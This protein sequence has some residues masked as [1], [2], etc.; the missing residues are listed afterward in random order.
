MLKLAKDESGIAILWVA[1]SMGIIVGAAVLAIDLS[2]I[3]TTRTQLQN[4]ADAAALAAA[5]D[6]AWKGTSTLA[7][8]RQ[9]ATNTAIAIAALNRAFIDRTVG[10][11]NIS[12]S[13]VTFPS[14]SEVTVRTHRTVADGDPL[15]TY[16]IRLIPPFG[17]GLA[18]VQADATAMVAPASGTRGFFPWVLPDRYEDLDGDGVWDD[19][20]P[21]TDQNGNG[22]WDDD[23]PYT[24]ANGN[25]KW[26]VG[27]WFDDLDG[28]GEYSLRE[29]FEDLDGNGIYSADF[30]D[31]ILTG[32]GTGELYPHNDAGMLLVVAQG[33]PQST[34]T[35][36]FYYPAR[37]PPEEYYT[38]E[39]PLSGASIYQNWIMNKSPYLVQIG[40]HV[41]LEYGRM[42]GPTRSGVNDIISRCPTSF[43]NADLDPPGVDGHSHDGSI[44][45]PRIG[46]IAFFDPADVQGSS[47]KLVTI[48]KL[49]HWFVESMDQQNTVYGRLIEIVDALAIGGG[50][51]SGGFIVSV[52][53]VE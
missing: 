11:V 23:E 40:D 18:D 30:Y 1:V 38:G 44:D 19:P 26:D 12:G 41:R 33:D 50:G 27:E 8:R 22:E 14:E 16:F 34:L 49:S 36:G 42:R 45:C 17:N 7:E 29:P 6:L 20:E 10:P 46:A 4:A 31:P 5:Q 51:D 24:D 53:L 13:D 39:S 15:R 28:D 48:V 21:F 35:S 2:S 43:Y 3:Q 37:W 32:Y 25:G 47:N 9:D 52:R